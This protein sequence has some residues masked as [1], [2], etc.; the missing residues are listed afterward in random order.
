MDDKL[1]FC[2]EGMVSSLQYKLLSIFIVNHNG[3]PQA[4][5]KAQK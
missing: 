5:N 1:S 4:Q 3:F 2:L